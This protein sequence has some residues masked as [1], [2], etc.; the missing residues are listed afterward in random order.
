MASI[1]LRANKN[2]KIIKPGMTVLIASLAISSSAEAKPI[3]ASTINAGANTPE[4]IDPLIDSPHQLQM[5]GHGAT[6]GSI[7]IHQ[8]TPAQVAQNEVTPK[9]RVEWS[10]VNVCEEGGRWHVQGAEYSGGL[11]ISNTNWIAYGGRQFSSTAAF[12]TPDEQIVVAMRIQ[13]NAP[14]QDGCADW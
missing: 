8:L 2:R 5:L 1:E 7:D 9:E 12:A 3:I 13:P 6:I 4:I 11:G 14:D 10:R